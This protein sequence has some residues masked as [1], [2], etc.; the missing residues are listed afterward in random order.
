MLRLLLDVEAG[1]V[2]QVMV[3]VEGVQPRLV[4]GDYARLPLKAVDV[5]G[6]VGAQ[7]KEIVRAGRI[8]PDQ[9]P[10]FIA[11]H[12][13]IA[14]F[15]VAGIVPVA[16]LAA[17]HIGIGSAS[18]IAGRRID[19]RQLAN[20]MKRVVVIDEFAA[21]LRVDAG[22]GDDQRR[23]QRDLVHIQGAGAVAFAEEALVP[24]GAAVVGRID[25]D[26]VFPLPASFEGADDAGDVVVDLAAGGVIADVAIAQF[27]G[28]Q[29]V[30]AAFVLDPGMRLPVRDFGEGAVLVARGLLWI[31]GLPRVRRMGG[32]VADV[33]EEGLVRRRGIEKL[34]G[35]VGDMARLVAFQLERFA[36][37]NVGIGRIV[38][39]LPAGQAEVIAS[40]ARRQMRLAE[41]PFAAQAGVIAGGGQVLEEG[42]RRAQP[43]AFADFGNGFFQPV[44]DAD[45]RGG[46]AG[47]QA[48]ASRRADGRGRIGV[49][50][51]RADG[52]Q[53]V[54][55]RRM[56]F[57]VAV[58]A[59]SPGAVIIG[60]E[61]DDIRSVGHGGF[62]NRPV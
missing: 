21:D 22:A 39:A 33:E 58:A 18:V 5:L 46:L 48:G 2:R 14:V 28:V 61:E 52:G 8:A 9:L 1:Q 7:V 49:C 15:A 56:H 4:I 3:S 59:V 26:G 43:I 44:M 50:E 36:V 42:A 37:A 60:Q 30:G 53:R 47:Q 10:V 27:L 32:D 40:A 38:R 41:M 19:L 23:L 17:Q 12:A 11:D 55:G 51:A 31:V 24:D 25:D 29:L 20:G 54:E 35:V 57:G 45:L 16:A 34:N 13:Q 62:L 6:R